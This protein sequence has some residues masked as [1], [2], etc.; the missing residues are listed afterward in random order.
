VRRRVIDSAVRLGFDDERTLFM[1]TVV[2]DE[3]RPHQVEGDD[4]GRSFEEAPT[5]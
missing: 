3:P 2:E 1:V 4:V 5:K